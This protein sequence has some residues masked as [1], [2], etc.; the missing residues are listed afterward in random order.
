MGLFTTSLKEA[1]L[2]PWQPSQ[3]CIGAAPP[4]FSYI[5]PPEATG[6]WWNIW[7][8]GWEYDDTPPPLMEC[9]GLI[10][11][12]TAMLDTLRGGVGEEADVQDMD[13]DTKERLP[14]KPACHRQLV[15]GEVFRSL[16]VAVKRHHD[17]GKHLIRG[18]LTV[19]WV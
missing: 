16:S 19:S 9:T 7:N 13:K 17:R 8:L 15:C 11:R 6:S 14:V 1:P 5:A 18:L 3:N 2:K 4:H 10:Y 12:E